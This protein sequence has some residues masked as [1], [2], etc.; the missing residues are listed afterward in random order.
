MFTDLVCTVEEVPVDEYTLPLSK[1]EVVVEGEKN[2]YVMVCCCCCVC[3]CVRAC[4]HA[5]ACV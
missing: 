5:C 4:V 2:M 3:A 1:A